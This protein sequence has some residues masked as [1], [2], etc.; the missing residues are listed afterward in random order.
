ML[1]P[2]RPD[3]AASAANRAAWDVFK[4]WE[5]PFLTCFSN[6]DPITRGGEKVWQSTVPGAARQKHVRIKNAGHFLQEDKGP[7]LAATLIRFI[8][9]NRT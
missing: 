1:V 6:R 3:D 9:S 7:E 5:K 8:E 4:N 2:T